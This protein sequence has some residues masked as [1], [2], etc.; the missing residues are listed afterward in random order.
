MK[1]RTILIGLL[2]FLNSNQMS[3]NIIKNPFWTPVFPLEVF[4]VF[5]SPELANSIERE[6]YFPSPLQDLAVQAVVNFCNISEDTNRMEGKP[7]QTPAPF[8][9]IPVLGWPCGQSSA[10]I[11]WWKQGEEEAASPAVTA[12][13]EIES[14]S[15]QRPAWEL[16]RNTGK[17]CW[18]REKL[19]LGDVFQLSLKLAPLVVFSV[20]CAIP[21]LSIFLWI[22]L[23]WFLSPEWKAS[24]NSYM[25]L[26][27][28]K[29]ILD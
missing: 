7:W 10:Y 28:S 19:I 6:T 17:C 11:I 3:S 25:F 14:L 12:T 2:V 29:R 26:A 1:Y 20:P 27:A 22:N 23:N 8:H 4:L 24:C 13:V 5:Q 18:E 16:S 15:L 21:P 9:S